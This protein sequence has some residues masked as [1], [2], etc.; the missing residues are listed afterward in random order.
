MVGGASYGAALATRDE[1]KHGGVEGRVEASAECL[2][3]S[4][5]ATV[6][7]FLPPMRFCYAT[8]N[9][10]FQS[11]PVVHRRSPQAKEKPIMLAELL[12]ACREYGG[13]LANGEADESADQGAVPGDIDLEMPLAR[14]DAHNAQE[15][16]TVKHWGEIQGMCGGDGWYPRSRARFLSKSCLPD[17]DIPDAVAELLSS[18]ES[19]SR[20]WARK[21]RRPML[22]STLTMRF[23][24]AKE[25][26]QL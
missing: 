12:T 24:V 5:N 1:G 23:G 26:M 21:A 16:I 6:K 22:S 15:I 17:A 2:W 4:N 3:R 13:V 11:A 18:D 14:L 20:F 8:L 10:V 7:R 25:Q 9:A 19:G